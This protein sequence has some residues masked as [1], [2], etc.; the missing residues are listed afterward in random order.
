MENQTRKFLEDI[1]V[2]YDEMKK[3]NKID[4]EL[5]ERFL[6]TIVEIYTMYTS[7]KEFSEIIEEYKV[8][9]IYN[10]SKVEEDITPE[11]QLGIGI[12]Y[13]YINDFDFKHDYFN[14]FTTSLVIHQKLY[15]KCP[16]QGF[17]GSLR[18]ATAMLFDTNIDVLESKQA[19]EEFDKYI[20]KTEIF[21]K[22][23]EGLDINSYIE[24]CIV[25]TTELIKLQPFADGNKRTFRSLFNL[26]LKKVNLP[27]VYV[28]NSQ[29]KEYKNALIKA[30]KYNEY[31]DL[32]RFY[33]NRIYDAI[34]QLDINNRKMEVF[35]SKKP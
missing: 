35:G 27:P 24:K 3:N 19:Q 31:N 16:G 10:E 4:K 14:I 13:D 12:V 2:T 11:E 18:E 30:M 9:Y 33:Y 15:S 29:K 34:I 22:E 1:S 8:R 23:L 5:E 28:D 7:K 25:L 20:P 17:G 32:I 6:R 26:L 21:M